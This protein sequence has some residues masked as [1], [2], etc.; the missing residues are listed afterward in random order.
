MELAQKLGRSCRMTDEARD[1]CVQQ[2]AQLGLGPAEGPHERLVPGERSEAVQ[3]V[4]GR[5]RDRQRIGAT[6][7]RLAY[8][9]AAAERRARER[10]G[11]AALDT[12]VEPR[13]MTQHLDAPHPE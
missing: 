9:A 6:R 4:D 5:R 7:A 12:G 8:E 2:V 10:V 13:P 11:A 1:L 3:R